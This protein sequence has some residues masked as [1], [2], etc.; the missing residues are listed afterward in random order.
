[1]TKR[2]LELAGPKAGKLAIDTAIGFSGSTA[3][4]TLGILGAL[5]A[6]TLLTRK[7]KP[8]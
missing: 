4:W 5:T 2:R 7:A 6:A 3:A 1:M 8:A